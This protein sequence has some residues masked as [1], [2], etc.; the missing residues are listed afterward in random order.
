MQKDCIVKVPLGCGSVAWHVVNSHMSWTGCT[1]AS[2]RSDLVC[3]GMALTGRENRQ[4]KQCVLSRLKN[5]GKWCVAAETEPHE[6]P[7]WLLECYL[8]SVQSWQSDHML[9]L[10]RSCLY[11]VSHSLSDVYCESMVIIRMQ[12]WIMTQNTPW[13]QPKSVTW[14][15]INTACFSVTEVKAE[16]GQIYKLAAVGGSCSEAPQD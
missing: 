11:N 3:A 12:C 1:W 8:S 13:K 14:S 6:T 4:H 2:L 15:Q 7:C 10:F 16:D 5:S 9:N